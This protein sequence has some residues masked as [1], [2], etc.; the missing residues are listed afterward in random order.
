MLELK[1]ASNTRNL[2]ILGLVSLG[3]F[4]LLLYFIYRNKEKL[5]KILNQ[6]NHQLDELE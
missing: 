5:N 6:R 4:S 2:L 3:I 1:Q